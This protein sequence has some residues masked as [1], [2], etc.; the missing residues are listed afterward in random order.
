MTTTIL[1]LL[2]ALNLTG[3]TINGGTDLPVE[4]QNQCILSSDIDCM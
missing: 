2:I 1:A 4:Q 3:S